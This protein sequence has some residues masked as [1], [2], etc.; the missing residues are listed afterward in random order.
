VTTTATHPRRFRLQ[1]SLRML[2]LLMAA[3]GVALAIYRWPWEETVTSQDSVEPFADPQNVTKIVQRTTYRRD[4]QG[5]AVKHGRAQA[6]EDGYLQQEEH[7]YDGRLHGQRKVFD[8]RGRTTQEMSFRDGQLHG[9]Y[10]SG[11]GAKWLWQG[12][13]ARNE[14]DGE[15]SGPCKPY[16]YPQPFSLVFELGGAAHYPW[17][18]VPG[19]AMIVHSRWKKGQRHGTW[20]WRTAAGNTNP[21]TTAEYHHDDLVRWNGQR[22]VEQ[23]QH[24]LKGPEVNDRLLVSELSAAESARWELTRQPYS[25]DLTFVIGDQRHIVHLSGIRRAE[26]YL[27][28][29]SSGS[30]VPALCE[31]AARNDLRFAYRYGALWL[32]PRGAAARP[33]VDPTGISQIVFADNSPQARDWEELIPVMSSDGAAATC[34]AQLLEHT[35]LSCEVLLPEEGRAPVESDLRPWQTLSPKELFFKRRR[36]DALAYILFMTGC[37]CELHGDTLRILPIANRSEA[38]ALV[39][40]L[41]Y[42]EIPVDPFH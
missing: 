1:V 20:T 2:L 38:Q 39:K 22:V 29:Q 21:E 16:E 34:V 26:L 36:R 6:W 11:D 23:F 3:V 12:T 17:A 28:S 35:S 19:N 13:Y 31:L 7:Y 24:W 33:F 25:N 9:P 8:K 32:L 37:R 18:H 15:W 30:F 14:W 5:R 4:W 42:V 41:K 40:P 27:P 10:R